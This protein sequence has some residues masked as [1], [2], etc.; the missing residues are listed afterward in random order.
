MELMFFAKNR[1]LA[2]VD[3][4]N[5]AVRTRTDP[6]DVVAL[7][8]IFET[9]GAT[10]LT[11]ACHGAAL[12]I[13]DIDLHLFNTANMEH[14]IFNRQ[15][16]RAYAL[17]HGKHGFARGCR[18]RI[19]IR[20]TRQAFLTAARNCGGATFCSHHRKLD[21]VRLTI[22]HQRFRESIR[23]QIARHRTRHRNHVSSLN[24]IQEVDS[25]GSATIGLHVLESN[26]F[27]FVSLRDNLVQGT[28]NRDIRV[29]A[30]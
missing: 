17:R 12:H 10:H 2:D 13:K 30:V 21:F 3:V 8:D 26:R 9:D 4:T 25:P 11:K 14:T 15:R 6:H 20:R 18:R 7:A 5:Q 23:L 22:N 16:Y 1:Q 19:G 24:K 27:E 29:L 28:F